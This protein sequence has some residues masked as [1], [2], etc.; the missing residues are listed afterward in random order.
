MRHFLIQYEGDGKFKTSL[1]RR[2]KYIIRGQNLIL[3][4]VLIL[5]GYELCGD[6][7]NGQTWPVFINPCLWVCHFCSLL[8][9]KWSVDLN[10][11]TSGLQRSWS[12]NLDFLRVFKE[13][14][15]YIIFY[16]I[17]YNHSSL[18]IYGD[19]KM[20]KKIIAHWELA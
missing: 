17:L 19:K 7:S 8:F 20:Y 16:M 1:V 15:F 2:Y 9:I 13:I 12:S 5:H 4:E 11:I 10:F 6:H 3:F 18:C 14:F